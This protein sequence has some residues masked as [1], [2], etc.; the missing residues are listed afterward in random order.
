MWHTMPQVKRGAQKRQILN[1]AQC[2]MERLLPKSVWVCVCVFIWGGSKIFLSHTAMS[3]R[4]G[5]KS[6]CLLTHF[7]IVSMSAFRSCAPLFDC[8]LACL[9]AC[10]MPLCPTTATALQQLEHFLWKK[11]GHHSFPGLLCC[12]GCHAVL[13][14]FALWPKS[15]ATKLKLNMKHK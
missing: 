10:L 1:Y 11:G 13:L 9:S 4:C 15:A 8:L 7:H 3:L 12:S 14:N 2:N 5:T 6:R